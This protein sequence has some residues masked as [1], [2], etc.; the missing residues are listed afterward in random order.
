[1]CAILALPEKGSP[2]K[3]HTMAESEIRYLVKGW[4]VGDDG[5]YRRFS[6]ICGSYSAALGYLQ[7]MEMRNKERVHLKIDSIEAVWNVE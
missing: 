5:I 1:M 6:D 7:L 2:G 3:G 4:Q